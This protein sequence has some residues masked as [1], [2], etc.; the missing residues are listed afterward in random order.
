MRKN[1]SR[2][3]LDEKA[4]IRD[5]LRLLDVYGCYEEG[6][7]LSWVVPDFYAMAK[8]GVKFI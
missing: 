4:L 8:F 5:I 3:I 2:A 7:R 1:K 6:V